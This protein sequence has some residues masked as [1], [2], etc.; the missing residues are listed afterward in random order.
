MATVAKRT[1]GILQQIGKSLMLPIAVLPA[2]AILLRIGALIMEYNTEGSTFYFI[3]E[4]MQNGANAIFDN[5][6]ILFAV[7]V[8]LGM[9]EN[10]GAAGLAAAVGYLVMTQIVSLGDTEEIKLNTGVIG[11]IITGLIAAAMYNR[12]HDIKLPDWLQFFGGKRFVPM[13]TAFA[14]ALVGLVFLV[15]WPPIQGWISAAGNWLIGAGSPGLFVY[16]VINRLLLPFGL[17]HIVNTLVWFNVGEFADEAGKVVT[18]DLN[19]FFA[20]DPTAGMFMTGFYPVLMFALPAAC[21]AIIHEAK[22][23]KRKLIS[24][25][26]ISAALTA[27]VTG[28][29]EPIEFAFMF[30]A[31]VLYVVHAILTGVSMAVVHMLGIKHGFGFSAGAIDFFLNLNLATKPWLLLLIGLIYAVIYYVVFR[32]VIRLFNLKTPGREDD[33]QEGA[34][35]NKS[36]QLSTL[37]SQVLKA[38]GGK[39]NIEHLDAC[40]T[41]L[42]MTVKDEDQV[43]QEELRRLGASGVIKV[44]PGNLQAVFG[45]RSELLKEQIQKQM[46][47]PEEKKNDENEEKS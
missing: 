29:T 16:G 30:V 12:Y 45:T 31:P 24:G 35:E 23:S 22:P 5:L 37:A 34:V 14:M 27:F 20:G 21:L 39:E 2:A 15:I 8:A 6:P 11:G 13:V 17:H 26:M 10:A 33:E 46:E 19:R 9:A 28:V 43:D 38:I 44:G 4:V 18:G 1:V 40:I 42:R 36:S 3:G 32:A 25:V 7:G 47:A 41:R